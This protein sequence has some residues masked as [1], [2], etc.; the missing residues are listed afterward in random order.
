M[1]ILFYKKGLS[2]TDSK[3]R[4]LD[5]CLCFRAESGKHP[6][7]SL[8]KAVFSCLTSSFQPIFCVSVA[9][10]QY[11]ENQKTKLI[12]QTHQLAS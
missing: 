10:E 6:L 5:G 1:M 7:K 8:P 11:P 4:S 2:E 9:E 12:S 3:S